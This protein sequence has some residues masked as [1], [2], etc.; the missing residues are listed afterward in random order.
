M[1]IN[2]I[3]ENTSMKADLF[4]SENE[5]DLIKLANEFDFTNYDIMAICGRI[6]KILNKK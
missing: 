4:Y 2:Y 6:F 1:F 5:I 3:T